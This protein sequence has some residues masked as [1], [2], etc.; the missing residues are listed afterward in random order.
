M[1][2]QSVAGNCNNKS[3]R[4]NQ[5]HQQQITL[6]KS[7]MKKKRNLQHKTQRQSF[8]SQAQIIRINLSLKYHGNKFKYC[9]RGKGVIVQ[10]IQPKQKILN[11][12]TIKVLIVKKIKKK[13]VLKEKANLQ[14]FQSILRVAVPRQIT[15]VYLVKILFS[16]KL[17]NRS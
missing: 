2:K 9:K 10:M 12:I 6:K 1:G 8:Q 3:I 4:Q 11:T 15:K 14:R 7:N 17:Q 5:H 13:V 16:H